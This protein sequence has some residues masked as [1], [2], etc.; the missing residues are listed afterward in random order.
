MTAEE[1]P[2]SDGLLPSTQH[3]TPGKND[4]PRTISRRK[5]YLIFVVALVSL[6]CL[7]ANFAPYADVPQ[8]A[9][10][11]PQVEALVPSRSAEI[12][13]SVSDL[14]ATPDFKTKAVNW[15]AGAVQ[16]PYVVPPALCAVISPPSLQDGGLRR[17]GTRGSGPAVGRLRAISRLP[18][19]C[20]PIGVSIFPA[21][22]FPG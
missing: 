14:F 3:L 17:N 4:A 8:F 12:Y 21:S 18:F 22:V 20:I 9:A 7:R 2:Y 13:A 10:D 15:L 6:L 5:Q 19:G 1:K 16:V 11:C